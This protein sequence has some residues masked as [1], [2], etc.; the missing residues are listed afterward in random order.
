MRHRPQRTRRPYERHSRSRSRT[1]YALRPC[2]RAS[3]VR[4][5]SCSSTSWFPV[6]GQPNVVTNSLTASKATF[7]EPYLVPL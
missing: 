2:K 4:T 7:A 6:N 1:G 3:Q 5:S